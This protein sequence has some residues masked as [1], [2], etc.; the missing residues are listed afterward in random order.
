[1]TLPYNPKKWV[2]EIFFDCQTFH[3]LYIRIA[4]LCYNQILLW[5]GEREERHEPTTT[6]L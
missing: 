2:Q 4:P 3:L 5:K 1:M 6:L